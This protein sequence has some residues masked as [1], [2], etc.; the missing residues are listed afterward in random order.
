MTSTSTYPPWTVDPDRWPDVAVAAGS[1]VRAAVARVLF[2]AAVVRLPLRVHLPGGSLH[3][4]GGPGTPVMRIR[5]PREFFRRLGASGLIG[6]GESYLAGEWDSTDLTGLLTVF[7]AHAAE[8]VPPPLQRL[9]QLAVRRQPP[10][11]RQTIAGARHNIGRHYDLS[12]DLF[13]LF[14]DETMTYSCALFADPSAPGDLEEA[15]RRK[16]DRLLDRAGVGWI[17]KYIFPGGLLPSLVAIQDSLARTRLRITARED[18][19]AHYAETL[20]LARG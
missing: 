18:F 19:G 9:R 6:F 11:D 17:Q 4:A 1:P 2:G 20:T 8:L 16:I 10:G 3:G 12:N 7:A 14:L 13:A 5:R 15:Q